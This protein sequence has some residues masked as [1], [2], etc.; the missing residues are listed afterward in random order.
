MADKVEPVAPESL[1][2]RTQP[3]GFYGH[4]MLHGYEYHTE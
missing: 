1:I 2:V 4:L 3:Y